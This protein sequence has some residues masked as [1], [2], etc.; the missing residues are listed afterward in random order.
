MKN[1]CGASLSFGK[2]KTKASYMSWFAKSLE[3]R[4]GLVG[5]LVGAPSCFRVTGNTEFQ[6]EKKLSPKMEEL[7]FRRM[8]Q[9]KVTPNYT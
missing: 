5:W 6:L 1:T 7:L 3:T 8:C 2:A 9:K 4:R